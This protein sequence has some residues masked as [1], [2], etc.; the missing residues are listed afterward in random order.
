MVQLQDLVESVVCFLQPRRPR[1]PDPG[2]LQTEAPEARRHPGRVSAMAGPRQSTEIADAEP[3]VACCTASKAGK[4]SACVG[5]RPPVR[6]T[7]R[8]ELTRGSVGDPRPWTAIT[9]IAPKALAQALAETPSSVQE[10]WFA[11]L[12]LVKAVMFAVMS[13]FWLAERR[14]RARAGLGRRRSHLMRRGGVHGGL[15]ASLLV[16][17]RCGWPTS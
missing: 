3:G 10:R 7:T 15:A 9:G 17:G 11:R 4:P 8:V 14:D 5:W 12:Y 16:R 13:I 1:P 6:T 2:G